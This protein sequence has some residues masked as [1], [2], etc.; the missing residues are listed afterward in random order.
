MSSTDRRGKRSADTFDWGAINLV[1]FDVD[2]TL[3]ENT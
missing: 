2:G 1:V 3:Y